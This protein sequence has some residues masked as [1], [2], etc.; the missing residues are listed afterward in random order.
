LTIISVLLLILVSFNSGEDRLKIYLSILLS[1]FLIVGCAATQKEK[2]PHKI[3]TDMAIDKLVSEI[4]RSLALEERPKIAVVDLLGPNDVHTQLGSFISEKL[5]TK[6]FKS[7]RFEKVLERKLLQDLLAQQRIEM[8]GYFDQDTVRSVV[9]KIGIDALVMGFV[10]DYGSRVDV[11]ARLIHTNGEILSVA[12]AQIDKDQAVNDMLQAVK[13]ATLTVALD[14]SDVQASVTVGDRVVKTI[15]GIAVFKKIPQGNRGIIVAAKGYEMIQENVY[16]TKDKTVTIPLP[17]KRVSLTIKITPHQG[18]IFL[19]GENKG[20]ASDGVMALREVPSGKHTILAQSE[21]YLPQT[22]DIE[23]YENKTFSIILFSDPLIKLANLKQDKPSF[24][25]DIWTD[26]KTY[27][28]GEEIRFYF[29]SDMDCYLTLVDYETNG[30]VKVLFP[31]R[32]SQNNFI[33][34]GN[35]YVIPGIDFGFKLNVEPPTGMERIK[36]IATT[37]PF[38]LYDLDFTKNVFAP[39]DRGNTRGMRGISIAMDRLPNYRWAES[40]CVITIR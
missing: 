32:Y 20:E 12:E 28:I 29:R 23:L 1:A 24:H 21:G 34:A 7:G 15:S 9:G 35:T 17:P 19:D 10:T 14:P 25:I 40:S 2:V 39:V 33:K 30:N 5:V 31:N 27:R 37:E 11:N 22:H 18:V 26:R 38:S 36:A 3:T 16:L 4:I 13:K 6:L 8:E